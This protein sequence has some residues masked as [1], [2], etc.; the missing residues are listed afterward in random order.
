M[1]TAA[2]FRQLI[3]WPGPLERDIAR[4][5]LRSRRAS[6]RMS[7]ITA[8]A[9]GGVAVGVAALIVV[10]GVMN[11]LRNDLRERILVANPHLRILTYGNGL[12]LDDWRGIL[13]RVRAEPGVLA[14]APEVLSQSVISA[15]ADYAEGVNV[16]GFDPDTGR[17]A[18]T[19]LPQT[20]QRGD[21]SFKPTR[22]GVD[23]AIILG[24][25]LA[26]RLT[27]YP[28]D[29]VTL[30]PAKPPQVNRALGIGVPKY[31]KFEVT[32]TFDTGMF[33][34]DN[35]FVVISREAAQRFTGLGDAVSG[36]QVRLA[37]PWQ[38]PE[39]GRRIERKL[40]YPYRTL[41]WQTQNA[42][43]FSALK[44]EKVAMGLI[45]FFIMVVAAFNIVAT[46]TMVVSEKT[47]EIGILRAMGLGADAIAR[48]FLA[49][50]AIIGIFGVALGLVAGVVVSVVVDRSHL[51]RIDPAVY[52]IDHLPIHVEAADVFIVLAGSFL[53]A[54]VATLHP[55]RAAS[56]MTPV[57]AIRYE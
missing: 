37:D 4:R 10:L 48:V 29:V 28:G 56:R 31:W 2:G 15:G 17:M 27:V 54:V 50:G 22:D 6:G 25:R 18:V 5:Y 24:A 1:T 23:G 16:L 42:T 34:Y 14:A 33:L 32:G 38:A 49:Q 53:L 40:G 55:S 43:L 44:L 30:V 52:F 39:I 47:R 41:D 13:D 3:R 36:I 7:L 46:L 8:I 19:T 26:E 35:Q 51:I 20:I 12:R 21:L 57:E 9:T 11:G 45:I